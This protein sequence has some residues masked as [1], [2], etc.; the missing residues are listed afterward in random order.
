MDRRGKL[1][2]R[3][4]AKETPPSPLKKRLR[5]RTSKSTTISATPV[6]GFDRWKYVWLPNPFVKEPAGRNRSFVVQL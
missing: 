6:S 3:S 1:Y 5:T 4:R 2:I